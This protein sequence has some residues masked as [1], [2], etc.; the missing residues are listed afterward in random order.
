MTGSLNS[1][2]VVTGRSV[3]S[4]QS[5]GDSRTVERRTL[6]VHLATCFS[7]RTRRVLVSLVV[8]PTVVSPQQSVERGS[9][10]GR[11]GRAVKVR[12]PVS[13]D[14]RCDPESSRTSGLSAGSGDP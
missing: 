6:N 4:G 7:R 13:E 9:T 14:A 2:R 11:S 5:R 10:S 1:E 8:E 12:R 3:V